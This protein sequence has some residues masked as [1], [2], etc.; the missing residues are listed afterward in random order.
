M[1]VVP[2]QCF[3]QM[4][5]FRRNAREY[6]YNIYCYRVIIRFRCNARAHT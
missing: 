2:Y 4:F 6:T 5:Y 1:F 3:I